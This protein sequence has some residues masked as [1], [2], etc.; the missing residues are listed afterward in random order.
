VG[1]A[2][3]ATIS[4]GTCAGAAYVFNTALGPPVVQLSSST[5]LAAENTSSIAITV[6]RS[7]NSSNAID[8][9]YTTSNG[10]AVAGT[11]YT[12]ASGTLHWE[13]GRQRPQE[14]QHPLIDQH[15]S[16]ASANDKT[17][18]IGLS[19]PTGGAT[20]GSP[21]SAVLTITGGTPPG[22]VQFSAGNYP[23]SEGAGSVYHHG[24]AQQLGWSS[25]RELRD[26]Q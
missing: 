25:Q 24:D 26:E 14:L 23:V 18:N 2:D 4:G 12:A 1:G 15:Q 3:N 5:Y 22:T 19:S 13:C 8:V 16:N 20:L 17:V 21:N 10:T 9:N 6:N 11:N 7:G